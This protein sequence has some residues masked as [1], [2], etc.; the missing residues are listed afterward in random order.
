M[1]PTKLDIDNIVEKNKNSLIYLWYYQLNGNNRNEQQDTLA[2]KAI[3][4]EHTLCTLDN[5]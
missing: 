3:P 2:D 5:L 4:K 1:I